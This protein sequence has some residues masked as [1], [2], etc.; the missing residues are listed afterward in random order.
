MR[1]RTDKNA[2]LSSQWG[3]RSRGYENL[4]GN[5]TGRQSGQ[6]VRTTW[7]SNLPCVCIHFD[8]GS[9]AWIDERFVTPI[10]DGED[11]KG[12]PPRKAKVVKMGE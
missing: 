10:E 5:V 11:E 4:V 12:L 6:T 7:G 8:N 1:V 2:Y 3:E 9:W